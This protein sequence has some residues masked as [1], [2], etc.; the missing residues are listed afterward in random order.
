MCF[1]S[2]N[3]PIVSAIMRKRSLAVAL[4]LFWPTIGFA[5][6]LPRGAT[7][8]DP[9][10]VWEIESVS[11][12]EP[13]IRDLNF[14]I[15]PDDKWIAYI[16]KGTIWKCSVSAGP[17]VKLVDVPD[18]ITARLAEPAWRNEWEVVRSK[19]DLISRS[20]FEGKIQPKVD[21]HSLAWTPIQDGIVFALSEPSD[22]LKFGR[23]YHV[24]RTS[25]DS[26]TDPISIFECSTYD[27]PGFLRTFFVTRDK[28]FVIVSNGYSPMIIDA[29]TNRPRVTPFDVLIPSSTS[30]RFLG[31]EIDTR[32]LVVIGEDFHVAQRFDP[33]FKKKCFCDLTWSP[34]ERYAICR[35]FA[36]FPPEPWLQPWTG[37]RIDLNTGAKRL[38]EGEYR[39][40]RWIFTGRGAECVRIG[41]THVPN[42]GYGDGRSGLFI[43][44][45]P[46]GDGEPRDLIRFSQTV[47]EQQAVDYN[48]RGRYPPPTVS[49]DKSLFAIA[50]P[51]HFGKPGFHYVLIDRDGKQR[52]VTLRDA[53]G[54]SR[55]SFEILAI[56]NH[57]KT[58][59]ACDD[60]RLFSIPFDVATSTAESPQ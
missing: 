7:L 23:R 25:N 48:K 32:Q 28:K 55:S 50:L 27:P 20:A 16:S 53:A 15:S 17:P 52:P 59:V 37:F 11:I 24:M 26:V 21:V 35:E 34:D 44:A 10:L 18:S 29:T 22:T 13:N 8:L 1:E 4:L 60:S 51:N 56:A 40:D 2:K 45:I 39:Y 46:D 5:S 33:E 42:G 36:E 57:G 31:I 43:A 6:D 49:A 14:A 12:A 30:G 3:L 54:Q 38:L 41:K 9:D 47:A 58:I 19:G